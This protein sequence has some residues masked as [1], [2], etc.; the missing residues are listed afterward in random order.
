VLAGAAGQDVEDLA[1]HAGGD[2]GV[3]GVDGGAFGAVGGGGVQQLDVSPDVV[4]GEPDAAAVL[5]ML[6]GE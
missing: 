6:A 1:G 3:G 2:E 4:C 5:E